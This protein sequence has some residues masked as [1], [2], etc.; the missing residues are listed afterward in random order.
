MAPTGEWMISSTTWKSTRDVIYAKG[1][2]QFSHMSST[3]PTD[4]FTDPRQV[5][6]FIVMKWG[7]IM[8]CECEM[9]NPVLAFLWG[10]S[11][12]ADI[13]NRVLER[14]RNYPSKHDA[15]IAQ[16]NNTHSRRFPCVSRPQDTLPL[17]LLL[18]HPHVTVGLWTNTLELVAAVGTSLNKNGLHHT[19][20]SYIKICCYICTC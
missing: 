11:S 1:E 6:P 7:V 10:R 3:L 19:N 9:L 4:H 13:E 5:N 2:G 20:S 12:H 15:D 18:S 8:Y 16:H 14:H 17:F